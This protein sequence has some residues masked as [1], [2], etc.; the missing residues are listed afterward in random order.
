MP[1][2]FIGDTEITA[3]TNIDTNQSAT[4]EEI[5]VIGLDDPV[6][7][8]HEA[9]LE[10]LT[11]D[12]ALI[13]L[14]H[15][16]GLSTEQQ[17]ENALAFIRSAAGEHSIDYLDWA[18]WLSISDVDAP[19]SGNAN[20]RDVSFS[21]TY[22]PQS[23]YVEGVSVKT[24]HDTGNIERPGLISLPGF[25]DNVKIYNSISR[26]SVNLEP[27]SRSQTRNG[28]VAQY[29]VYPWKHAQNFAA[30]FTQ[31]DEFSGLQGASLN[32]QGESV[33]M[34][35]NACVQ[36]EHSAVV[37]LR[38]NNI[39]DDVRIEIEEQIDGTWSTVDSS[40]YTTGSTSIVKLETE[41]VSISNNTGVRI[42]VS[43]DTAAA[44]HVEV[45]GAY[46]KPNFVPQILFDVSADKFLDAEA[47]AWYKLTE[48]NGTTAQDYS[49]FDFDADLVNC[50]W[51][52]IGQIGAFSL[53][54]DSDGYAEVE[55]E[56]E[57]DFEN[58]LTVAAWIKTTSNGSTQTVVS[59]TNGTDAQ[60]ALKYND[61]AAQ[62]QIYDSGTVTA[63]GTTDI[64]DDSWHLLIGSYD[65]SDVRIYVDGTEEGS[66][67]HSGSAEAGFGNLYIGNREQADEYVEGVVQNVRLFS[68]VLSNSERTAIYDSPEA[69]LE[70][71]GS[72][73]ANSRI[74]PVRVFDD[75][76]GSHSRVTNI[77][78][79]FDGNIV[80]SNE[81]IRVRIEDSWYIDAYND[82]WVTIASGNPDYAG[83]VS[84][85]INTLNKHTAQV[86]VSGDTTG[87]MWKAQLTI[88][89]GSPSVKF[90][91]KERTSES[92]VSIELSDTYAADTTTVV[93]D[94]GT[95]S[96][97]D[98]FMAANTDLGLV[99]TD[100]DSV[101]HDGT[102]ITSATTVSTSFSISALL[103]DTLSTSITDLDTSQ[104]NHY[105]MAL[106]VPEGLQEWTGATD[107]LTIS[108][109]VLT[110]DV[111]GNSTIR[112]QNLQFGKSHGDNYRLRWSATDDG[113]SE[114][115]VMEFEFGSDGGNNYYDV[116]IDPRDNNL[117]ARKYVDGAKTIMDRFGHTLNY[118][119]EYYLEIDWDPDN[120]TLDYYSWEAGTGKPST[121]NLSL[122][123][124]AHDSGVIKIMFRRDVKVHELTIDAEETTSINNNAVILP[125]FY[126]DNNNYVTYLRDTVN[127]DLI[128]GT[129]LMGMRVKVTNP[130]AEYGQYIDNETD[131]SEV[132]LDGEPKQYEFTD[133]TASYD[134]RY[135]PVRFNADDENDV[136]RYGPQSSDG[137]EVGHMV[138]DQL[139]MI[140]VSLQV[141]SDKLGPQD[142][143]H[144]L[145][146]SVEPESILQKKS[147]DKFNPL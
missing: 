106:N 92:T 16:E 107:E 45:D 141:D 5:D 139:Y 28:T 61:S 53:D 80:I 1:N 116:Y 122:N 22:L 26:D 104:T 146:T 120:D 135:R 100:F 96:V 147:D 10:S 78:H 20:L 91:I 8:E 34:T 59:K 98:W 90:D 134:Y 128:P 81:M 60:Y 39:T 55:Y 11:L 65:G 52:N 62:F 18:G 105:E 29:A 44:N 17:R 132:A 97:N 145:T 138:V 23:D 86:T 99:G 68:K 14:I 9:D 126:I 66:Q 87:S 37:R 12:A 43:N 58:S 25:V 102:E 115:E 3:I 112:L 117:E 38:D 19:R 47:V 42:T 50:S 125:S 15:S 103:L 56:E 69:A 109:G 77:N 71:V 94:S 27:V 48:G 84:S 24:D 133:Y 113:T 101:T 30:E 118:D 85:H 140:P 35:Y 123:D 131:S 108:G 51:S 41:I 7:V 36:G 136:I 82:Q 75:V 40:V 111:Q 88:Q 129:Y 49:Q 130:V 144:Q 76:G 6:V 31:I 142:I 124:G 89:R 4:T 119:T 93:N 32:Q 63:T 83:I 33:T 46:L 73:Q 72:V 127:E 121:P 95:T 143:A 74:S 137:D 79:S 2:E 64:G 21:A 70:R 54:P 13:K 67:S 114:A 57:F 110:H